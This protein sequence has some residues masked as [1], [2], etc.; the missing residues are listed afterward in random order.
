MCSTETGLKCIQSFLY[1]NWLIM[2]NVNK[3]F[4]PINIVD[5]IIQHR[6]K[7]ESIFFNQFIRKKL[8]QYT[9]LE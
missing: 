9:V 6:Q 3:M 4:F 1:R 7:R 5:H 8:F 2:C